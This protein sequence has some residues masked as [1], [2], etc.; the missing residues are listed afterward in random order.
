MG[1]MFKTAV[2]VLLAIILS[3]CGVS[4]SNEAP[5]SI[6]SE[7]AP[8]VSVES[9]TSGET[10][11]AEQETANDILVAYFS[12]TGEN[13]SVGV[14]EKGNTAI[15]AEIIAAQTGGELFEIKTV[16]A[17]PDNYDECTEIAQSEKNENA[18]PE[19]VE[20][21]DNLDGYNTIYLGYPIWW[22]DMPMA[23]YTFL[24]NNDFAGKTIIPFC[25]HAGSGLSDTVKKISAAC[26]S[27]TV[28]TGLAIAGTTAQND[29]E[30]AEQSVTEWL[31]GAT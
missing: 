8:A 12:R 7:S 18:R 27:A 4:S 21:K 30:T 15:V 22:G 9:D 31:N 10:P 26:P 1:K 11:L 25:T 28:K 17:Y 24:E 5:S 20:N 16:N 19:L 13:Y 3:A 6:P 14:I 23:V 2:F 29:R